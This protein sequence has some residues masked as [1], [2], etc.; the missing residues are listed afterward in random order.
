V[1]GTP[2]EEKKVRVHVVRVVHFLKGVL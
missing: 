2:F 1:S